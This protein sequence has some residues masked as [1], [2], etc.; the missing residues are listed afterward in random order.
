MPLRFVPVNAPV[1][2]SIDYCASISLLCLSQITH[3][4]FTTSHPY[5]STIPTTID[6]DVVG[7]ANLAYSNVDDGGSDGDGDGD[8]KNERNDGNV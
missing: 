2:E 7:G 8:L 3:L 4:D 6:I 1:S 5:F